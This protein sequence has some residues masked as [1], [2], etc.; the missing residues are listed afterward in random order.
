MTLIQLHRRLCHINWQDDCERDSVNTKFIQ[1]PVIRKIPAC[2]VNVKLPTCVINLAP[3]HE[4]VCGNV[5]IVPPFLISALEESVSFL[6]PAALLQGK[7]PP[8]THRI[9]G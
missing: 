4:D 3:R 1:L 2:K 7:E 8:L 5:S 6:A 9:G